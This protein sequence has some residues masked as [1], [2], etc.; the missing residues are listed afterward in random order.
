MLPLLFQDAGARTTDDGAVHG[1]AG[2]RRRRL[3]GAQHQPVQARARRGARRLAA[4]RLARRATSRRTTTSS[5]ATCRCRSSLE[6]D[7][8]RNNAL[9][10][11]RREARLARRAAR[12]Q[13]ARLR[14]LGLL[15]A[16][17]RVR[18]QAERA[19]GAGARGGRAR[20]RASSPTAAS[21]ASSS[22][23]GARV[24]VVARALDADGRR[25]PTVT[26]RGAVCLSGSAVGSAALALASGLPDP[27]RASAARC[28]CTR[29]WRWPA[30]STSP[31]R[32]GS[33]SRR[34]TSAPRSCASTR[35]RRRPRL[36][37]AG[38]RASDRAGGG[39]A[40]LRRGAHAAHAALPAPRGARRHA[41]RRSAGTVTLDERAPA[42]PLRARP[43]RSARARCT[44]M[45][46]CAELLFAAGA[47]A[48]VRAVRRAARARLAARELDAHRRARLP[49]ARSAAHR[50]AP[51]GHAAARPRRRRARRAGAASRACRSPTAACSRPASA[52]RRSSRFM[53]QRTRSPATSSRSCG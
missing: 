26:V 46:A 21:S 32:A 7:L 51:D 15:R 19:Q 14:A 42:H 10:A 27:R 28:A 44:G 35:R 25:G 48:V 8:N 22:R 36:D 12:A 2:P 52:A 47:R 41:A 39:A 43:R 29:A 30:S 1:A 50:G 20:A 31:S 17:L 37:R 3:D 4:R 23:T 49:A 13:P 40:R 38:V 24:G 34:A 5:S 18:R 11:R 6:T 53:L 33:A 16:G 45:R 9:L